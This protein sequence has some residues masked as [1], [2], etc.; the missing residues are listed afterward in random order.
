MKLLVKSGLE[1]SVH[2]LQPFLDAMTLD[3]LTVDLDHY[4]A[5]MPS[6]LNRH[7]DK[8]FECN[9]AVDDDCFQ[10]ICVS[11]VWHIGC[12]RCPDCGRIPPKASS[13][14]SQQPLST[15]LSCGIDFLATIQRVT[16]LQQYRHLLWV[17]L[18]RLMT[19]MKMDFDVLNC[20]SLDWK[21]TLSEH[22]GATQP[23]QVDC[24]TELAEMPEPD[25]VGHMDMEEGPS[26]DE[27][28][29]S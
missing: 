11:Q 17:A 13:K 6:L 7:A 1:T 3:D 9:A 23:G 27:E 10:D 29:T 8:C 15:C 20:I 12:F 19:T 22:E 24:A 4:K 2:S 21:V 28:L 26:A 14:S 5:R 18:A 16:I 25:Q